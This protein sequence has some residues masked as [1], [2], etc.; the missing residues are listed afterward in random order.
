[1]IIC[2]EF[3]VQKFVENKK[4]WGFRF[5]LN[6]ATREVCSGAKRPNSSLLSPGRPA[7]LSLSP[8]RPSRG[9]APLR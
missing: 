9:R 3:L 7:M 6:D 5:Q 4:F 2:Q 8:T 1:M